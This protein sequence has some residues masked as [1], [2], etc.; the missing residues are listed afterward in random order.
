MSLTQQHIEEDLS[1]SYVQAVAAKA[2]VILSLGARNHDYKVD[3][4]FH[5][6]SYPQRSSVASGQCLEL[7]G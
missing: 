1:R 3:G 7:R 5:Q 2:G 4:T 6:V